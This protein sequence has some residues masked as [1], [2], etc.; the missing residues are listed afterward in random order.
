[1]NLML[2]CFTLLCSTLYRYVNVCLVT[3]LIEHH[4]TMTKNSYEGTLICRLVYIDVIVAPCG[5]MLKDGFVS[6]VARQ[7]IFTYT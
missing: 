2:E 7:L 4:L 5:F 6:V 1:M 3:P